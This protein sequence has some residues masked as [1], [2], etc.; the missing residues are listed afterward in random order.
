VSAVTRLLPVNEATPE[1]LAALEAEMLEEG[2]AAGWN[3]FT[4]V[5]TEKLAEVKHVPNKQAARP[6]RYRLIVYGWK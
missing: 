4:E 1:K 3:H 6:N 5:Q 2:R